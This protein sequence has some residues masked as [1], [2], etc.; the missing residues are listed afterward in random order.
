MTENPELTPEEVR[1]LLLAE[2]AD[3]DVALT[4]E[5]IAYVTGQINET[6]LVASESIYEAVRARLTG[7]V[8][9]ET[10][11]AALDIAKRDAATLI[12]QMAEA[13]I[14]KAGAVIRD[15][16]AAGRGPRDIARNLDMVQGLD[17]VRA[18]QYLDHVAY[19][20][21]LDPPLAAAQIEKRSE[22]Y[23]QKLLKD[24]KEVIAQTEARY[25]TSQGNALRAAAAG[26]RFKAW[27]TV[28][29]E[30]VSDECA[31]NES[32]G[33]IGLEDTF[34]AGADQP[35]QHPRCRCTLIY[36]EEVRDQDRVRAQDRADRTKAAKAAAG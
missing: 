29:D 34:P 1:A 20:E 16:L 7:D 33:Y 30:R 9:Q 13:E 23:Y 26:K 14:R 10:L 24:R 6:M 3:I 19:L 31:A 2:L 4:N 17:S 36:R 8:A 27:I 25:A 5:M 15:G 35:P 18:K 28:G 21:N 22:A 12:T 32:E 11:D